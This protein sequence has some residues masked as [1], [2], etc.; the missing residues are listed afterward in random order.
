MPARDVNGCRLFYQLSGDKGDAL[1]LVHGSWVS[2]DHWSLVVPGLAE[3][4]RVLA[5]DRRGHSRSERPPAPDSVH[6]DVA[7]LAALIEELEL[8]PAWVAGNSFG[9]SIALRLAGA[10]PE[11]LRGVIA[12]EPPLFALLA[13]DPVAA[14]MV[15]EVGRRIAAVADRIASGDHAGA[16][17]QFVETIALG[18][19]GWATVPPEGRVALTANAQTFLHEARDPEQ[20]AID[21]GALAAFAGPALL[22]T[23]DQSPPTFAPVVEKLAAALPNAQVRVFPGA[24]H[25]PHV[26]H[27]DAYVDAILN[28]TTDRPA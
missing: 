7:D 13:D 6:D 23:G 2:L 16:A 20:I 14:P 11:L 28:F 8:A 5:Y 27:P 18:P 9:G 3:R 19:G 26:S 25:V 22:T 4:H 24:G 12:H 15:Q 1:V 21:L 17:E 10:R